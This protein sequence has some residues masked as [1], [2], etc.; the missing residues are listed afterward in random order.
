M[1]WLF[2]P[3]TRF[4]K[5]KQFF[6]MS[7]QFIRLNSLNSIPATHNTLVPWS[8][9][10]SSCL[11]VKAVTTCVLS[12]V[13][14]RLRTISELKWLSTSFAFGKVKVDIKTN[15]EAVENK[16]LYTFPQYVLEKI[17]T[18]LVFLV[19]AVLMQHT[20]YEKCRANCSA[21]TTITWGLIRA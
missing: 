10:Y 9:S 21:V 13:L 1:S 12:S 17:K 15:P 7:F 11:D 4:R 18:F 5:A 16:I 2:L 20:A 19:W 6:R 14:S 3:Y 8:V